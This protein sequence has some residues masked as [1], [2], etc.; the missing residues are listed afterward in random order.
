MIASW[1][2]KGLQAFYENGSLAGI[3]P[4]HAQKL[5]QRLS[6]LD[7]ATEPDDLNIPQYR[8]HK[9]VGDR[10]D[11]WSVTVSG[12]WRITFYFENGN[13]YVVNYEDYH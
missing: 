11:M 5:R 9:L 1:K 6:L 8:L 3:Q 13:A 4:K 7:V 10:K 2:H 12:N